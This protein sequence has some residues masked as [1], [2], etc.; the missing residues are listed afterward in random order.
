MSKRSLKI[1][2]ATTSLFLEDAFWQE[3]QIRAENKGISTADFL[4]GILGQI[5]EE[6]N[7]SA[8]IKEFLMLCLREEYQALL[9][10]KE[11]GAQSKWLVEIDGV[12][13]RHTFN[14]SVIT[15]GNASAND[16]VFK[17]SRIEPR[18]ILLAYDGDSWWMT[19]LNPKLTVELNGK[20]V[21]TGKLVKGSEISI[22]DFQIIKG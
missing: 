5:D 14:Q 3:I 20:A 7:R 8:A 9:R 12:R 22:E 13:T 21:Q 10:D 11:K 15:A 17:S 16:I 19:N 2:G 1:D 6:H 18:Q 4:R